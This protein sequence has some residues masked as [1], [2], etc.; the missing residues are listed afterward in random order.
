MNNI[1]AF[2][3]VVGL[4]LLLILRKYFPGR[5]WIGITLA[6]FTPFAPFYIPKGWWHFLG[7]AA[8][9]L[10]LVNIFPPLILLTY[11]VSAVIMYLRFRHPE[12]RKSPKPYVDAGV[13]LIHR[14][15]NSLS[16]LAWNDLAP[17]YSAEEMEAIDRKLS[18]FQK[19]ANHVAGGEARFH[20][21][22]I[23]D[24]RRT[25]AA[26]ALAELAGN[27]WKYS[28]E[29]P[30]NWRDCVATYLKAWAAGL[31][32]LVLLDLGELL[33]RAGCQ[34]EA[35]E[36]FRVVLLFPSYAHTYYR[37]QE[38]PGLVESIVTRAKESLQE[39]G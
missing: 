15:E 7:I 3:G 4:L 9:Y 33:E 32:P 24:L 31:S 1:I 29:I 14:L 36:A 34:N 19:T 25:L 18:S 28:D 6:L 38:K 20:P 27:P 8:L 10:V 39:L 11:P 5:L 21:E 35:R 13:A 26:E 30:T 17:T 23:Q 37:G 12:T 2:L 22:I 16:L